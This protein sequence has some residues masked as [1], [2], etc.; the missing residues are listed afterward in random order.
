MTYKVH[1]EGYH[2]MPAFMLTFEQDF[3]LGHISFAFL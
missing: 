1:R 2:R 3:L